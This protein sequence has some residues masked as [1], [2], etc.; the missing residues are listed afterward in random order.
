MFV[1]VSG[2][3][4]GLTIVSDLIGGKE[5]LEK[6]AFIWPFLRHAISLGSYALDS[7]T[8]DNYFKTCITWQSL[9]D[10]KSRMLSQGQDLSVHGSITYT[11]KP[12]YLKK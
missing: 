8:K 10:N 9:S 2:D 12:D 4:G 5:N 6:R 1:S 11:T 3:Q 7:V